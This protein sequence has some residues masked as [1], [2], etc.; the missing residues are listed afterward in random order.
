MKPF[1]LILF[2]CLLLLGAAP[3]TVAV[4]PD[5]PRLGAP[6]SITFTLADAETTLA[7]L[8]DLGSLA[9]LLPPQ[10]DG[11]ELRLLLMPMRSG[12]TTLPSLPLVRGSATQSATPLITFKVI[13]DLPADATLAPIRKRSTPAP[14]QSWPAFLSTGIGG[15]L[16]VA[17]V[18]WMRRSRKFQQ[19]PAPA[20][21]ALLAVWQQQLAPHL[22]TSITACE[23]HAEIEQLRF[24]PPSGD[25]AATRER[26]HAAVTAF[27]GG[28]P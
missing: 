20:G 19:V 8:P 12:E 10:R 2:A 17:G 4:H 7:G 28:T 3:P 23:L 14:M 9:L 26:L 27:H 25:E 16:V 18:L 15:L 5:P 13:D 22:A 1:L 6:L 24:A 11:R 21:D